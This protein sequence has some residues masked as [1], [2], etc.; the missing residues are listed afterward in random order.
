MFQFLVVP[1]APPPKV[2]K[3]EQDFAKMHSV[4]HALAVT[5]CTTGL[6]LI[7]AA[8]GIGLGD[9]VIGPAFTWIATAN[10]V[11]YCGATPIFVDVSTKTFNMDPKEIQQTKRKMRKPQEK[12][13]NP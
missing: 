9:E 3:F 13:V 1:C 11:E 6:H 4:K 5:S 8:M 7:L 12:L 10:V 2:A